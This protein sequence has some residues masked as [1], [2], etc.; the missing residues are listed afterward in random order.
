MPRPS[1]RSLSYPH[2]DPFTRR[3]HA[4]EF[5]VSDA[6]QRPALT[7]RPWRPRGHSRGRL[8]C[9]ITATAALAW[10]NT[11]YN[12]P[13]YPSLFIGDNMPTPPRGLHTLNT[14]SLTGA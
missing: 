2:T 10:Q 14:P 8:L 6:H 4:P 3:P 7:A 12:Q 1:E 11:A 13:P 5:T 9:G